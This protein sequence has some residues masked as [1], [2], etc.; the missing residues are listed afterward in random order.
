[1][2]A[3]N[4]F[5][6]PP[7]PRKLPRPITIHGD[8]RQDE[9]FWLR[10]REDPAV[11]RH[12]EAEN[13]YTEAMLAPVAALRDELYQEM[14]ARIEEADMSVPARRG[15]FLYYSRIGKGEQYHCYFRRQ[16]SMEAPEQLLLD[17][18]AMAAGKEY[19]R[20]GNFEPSPDQRLLAYSADFDGDEVY[21]IHLRDLATGIDQADEIPNTYYSL[22]WANDSRTFFYTVLDGAKRPFQV[23]RHEAGTPVSADSLIHEETDERFTVSV[24]KTLDGRFLLLESHSLATSEIR[25]LDA[26][27][28]GGTFRVA[29]PRRHEIEYEL[30]HREGY[31]Y[32]RIND[33]GRGFRLVR[34]A[35]ASLA[36][37]AW[38]ELIAH[39]PGI[40]LE[41]AVA[42]QAHLVLVERA[43]GL[44]KLRVQAFDGSSDRVLDMP[45]PVY[46]TSLGENYE[47]GTTVLRFVYTSLV[48]PRSVID[49][50][51]ATGQREVRKVAVVRGGYDPGNYT[52]ERHYA[53]AADG[54]AIPISVVHRAGLRRDGS[55]PALLY[56]YGSYGLTIEPG[57]LHERLSLLD[58]GFVFAIAHIRG[59]AEMG[60]EWHDHGKLLQKMNTFTDFIA[61]AEHLIAQGFTSP[62]RLAIEGRSAGG[63]LMG[64]VTNLRPDLFHAVVAGVPFVDTLNT[65]LDA[66]LPLTV[67][68]YDEWGNSNQPEFYQYIKSYSPYDN[69]A[70][71]P[72][73]HI[74]AT[75]GL[76]DPRVS[77]W[78]PAKWIARLRDN[79]TA[80]GRLILLKTTMGAGHFGKS[81][82][83]ERFH[84]IAFDYAF[85][86][87]ALAVE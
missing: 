16:G 18:N 71:R 27:D 29:L 38:E 85:M 62:G 73:P 58:R 45:E 60:K 4:G 65:C 14:V 68:E 3:P 32:I 70:P 59:G 76:N 23:W 51:M 22:E 9:Y 56:G 69:V 17:G 47:Y 78:E 46:T 55:A 53:Q 11:T 80:S 64:A 8:T 20:L 19:Y 6:Q 72:Y 24:S 83:Y 86:I 36:E 44:R 50:D 34:T 42:F 35:T 75:A 21:T 10:D 61:A 41:Q 74:L 2:N 40:T 7:V 57:F 79:N 28:P 37:N 12:L 81:G 87:H 31:F 30:T 25:Y 49:Y 13:A 54:T 15:D 63:L 84:D 67:G 52:T 43:D 82:R 48:A 1:M 26:G 39:R 77:Y 5:L 66:T 33:T